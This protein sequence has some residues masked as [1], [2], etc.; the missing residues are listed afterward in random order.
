MKDRDFKRHMAYEAIIIL[1][2]LAMLTFICRLWPLLLLVILGIIIGAIRMLFLSSEKEETGRT[3]I[4]LAMPETAKE[5]TEK[6]VQELAYCV[7]LRRVTELILSEY[8]EARWVWETPD[9]KQRIRENQEV[10]ILLGRAGGYRRARV[11]IRNLQV[12]GVEYYPVTHEAVPEQECH[13]PESDEKPKCQTPE[14]DEEPECQTPE[15]DEELECQTPETDE[16]PESQNYG[17][18]AFEW[19]DAHIFELNARCNEAIGG[20]LSEIILLAEELPVR[21]SWADICQELIRAGLTDTRCIPEGIRI[22]LTQPDAE[23]K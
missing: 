8:P 21:E 6:D 4:F 19:V 23:R 15:S 18:L 20:N 9:T 11:V 10:F 16:E 2:V 5:P 3:L 14:S 1:G 12:L 13:I 22:Y 7:I 17:L